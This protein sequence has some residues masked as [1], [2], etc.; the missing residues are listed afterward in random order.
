MAASGM[1][2]WA[3]STRFD[4]TS[5][6]SSVA[7]AVQ[8]LRHSN[9]R[10]RARTHIQFFALFFLNNYANSQLATGAFEVV[11]NG[12]TVFSKLEMGRMPNVD[13][14]LKGMEAVRREVRERGKCGGGRR[15]EVSKV[16]RPFLNSLPRNTRSTRRRRRQ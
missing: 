11:Y 9:T 16:E 6:V 10:A 2:C 7:G 8:H 3:I 5:P 4:S 14:V 15:G 12:R 13:E 1:I